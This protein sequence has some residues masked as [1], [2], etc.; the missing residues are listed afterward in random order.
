MSSIYKF[1][2]ALSYKMTGTF[3]IYICLLELWRIH[4]NVKSENI[5]IWIKTTDRLFC[6]S[7]E[8]WLY[9][10]KRIL[11]F[12]FHG[13]EKHFDSEK[14]ATINKICMCSTFSGVNWWSAFRSSMLLSTT[15]IEQADPESPDTRMVALIPGLIGLLTNSIFTWKTS[16]IHVWLA[17]CR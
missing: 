12:A 1:I 17:Y 11:L 7:L 13:K 15:P 10:N 9:F 5:A 16:E 6:D 2:E 3:K 8:N 14:V 4:K